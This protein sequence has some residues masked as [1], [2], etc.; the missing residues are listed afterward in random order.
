MLTGRYRPWETFGID[1]GGKAD[2]VA[3]QP[4]ERDVGAIALFGMPSDVDRGAIIAALCSEGREICEL[5]LVDT[6]L[7]LGVSTWK[8]CYRTDEEAEEAVALQP[9]LVLVEDRKTQLAGTPA[10]KLV[11]GH[12]IEQLRNMEH[13]FSDPDLNDVPKPE[14]FD[15]P[16]MEAFEKPA[17]WHEPI[18][19]ENLTAVKLIVHG[20]LLLITG[21][22]KSTQP[23]FF[24]GLFS[25]LT[26]LTC[27]LQQRP[28]DYRLLR[29]LPVFP[30]ARNRK[31]LTTSVFG[32]RT[33]RGQA[34]TF[35]KQ[36]FQVVRDSLYEAAIPEQQRR[37]D[38]H[39]AKDVEQISNVWRTNLEG[40]RMTD[41]VHTVLRRCDLR[42]LK[43]CISDSN[44]TFIVLPAL[45][46]NTSIA[47][48]SRLA[49]PGAVVDSS[50]EGLRREVEQPLCMLMDAFTE[51]IR[52]EKE[53]L[54]R[55]FELGHFGP[56]EQIKVAKNYLKRMRDDLEKA[57]VKAQGD[58]QTLLLKGLDPERL[59][60]VAIAA[61]SIEDASMPLG[62]A[63]AKAKGEA[64]AELR[65]MIRSLETGFPSAQ[66]AN[67]DATVLQATS[68][69][70]A[71]L[72]GQLRDLSKQ[73]C[74]LIAS[75]TVEVQRQAE[76]IR[77]IASPPIVEPAEGERHRQQIR[78]ASELTLQPSFEMLVYS[79]LSEQQALDLNAIDPQLR[80]M[81]PQ[82]SMRIVLCQ[83]R[84]TRLRH[85]G[86]VSEMAQDAHEDL[87][88]LSARMLASL[89]A[90]ET[91]DAPY[92]MQ[93][94]QDM[95]HAIAW[96]TGCHLK[97]A[98]DKLC[99]DMQRL[100]GSPKAE[101]ASL[102]QQLQDL[103]VPKHETLRAA[104]MLAHRVGFDLGRVHCLD[105]N[106]PAIGAE[107]GLTWPDLVDGSGKHDD[108]ETPTP[109]TT[110]SPA[111]SGRAAVTQL[112]RANERLIVLAGGGSPEEPA[113]QLSETDVQNALR[114]AE[115]RLRW[116][117]KRVELPPVSLMQPGVWSPKPPSVIEISL[118][119]D[120]CASMAKVICHKRNFVSLAASGLEWKQVEVCPKD[121]RKITHVRLAEALRATRSF[122]TA[123]WESFGV[124]DLRVDDYITVE[125]KGLA[126]LTTFYQ[127]ARLREG[128]GHGVAFDPRI[129]A[130]EFA[131]RFMLRP[132]QSTLVRE[133]EQSASHSLSRCQQMIMVTSSTVERA[134][135]AVVAPTPCLVLL[136]LCA[137]R[138]CESVSQ[139]GGKSAVV[140][141]LL[142]LLLADGKTLIVLV[143][144]DN[145]LDMS[146][147]V[148]RAAF[149]PTIPTP[150]INFA[151]E[152]SGSDDMQK[153]LRSIVRK[154]TFTRANAGVTCTTPGAVKSLFLT[155]IDRLHVEER[156]CKLLLLPKAMLLKKANLTASQ[157]DNIDRIGNVMKM[158]AGE[159]QLCRDI[160][161]ILKDGVALVDEV[162]M[163]LHP[164]RSELNFPI[165]S[166]HEL[167]LARAPEEEELLRREE[168]DARYRWMLPMHMLDAVMAALEEPVSYPDMLNKPGARET[169]GKLK[170]VVEVGVRDCHVSRTPHFTLLQKN[171]YD[172]RMRPELASWAMLFVR[173][174]IGATCVQKDRPT[175][176]DKEGGEKGFWD[177]A[178]DYMLNK[179]TALALAME[180][181]NARRDG[182]SLEQ[183]ERTFGRGGGAISAGDRLASTHARVWYA[184]QG[185]QT[186]ALLNLC[187]TYLT[188]LLPHVLSKRSRVDFGLLSDEDAKRLK[189]MEWEE[190]TARTGGSEHELTTE[191]LLVINRTSRE[192]LAVPFTGKDAPSKAAEFAIPE[193]IIGLT[194]AA[195]RIE[196]LRDRDIVR[197]LT[198]LLLDFSKDFGSPPDKR[199]ENKM[200]FA[201]QDAAAE[202]WA[203]LHGEDSEPPEALPLQMLQPSDKRHVLLL[204]TL[205]GREPQAIAYY[206]DSIVFE[207]TQ[208]DI[209]HGGGYAA[210]KLCASGMDLGSDSLFKCSVGFSGTPSDLLP[211]AMRPC[212]PTE[213]DDAK[214]INVL[215]DPD[216]MSIHYVDPPWSS[217][218]LLKLIARSRFEVLIDAGALITGKTNEQVAKFMLEQPQMSWAKA[219][220]FMD[221]QDR[222]QV[223][224]RGGGPAVPF[225]QV[226]IPPSD[227]FTFFDQCHVVG[228]DIK[229]TVNARAAVT[230]SKGMVLRDFAQACW[231]M[232]QIGVGQTIKII[233]VPEVV[234]LVDELRDRSLA[235]PSTNQEAPEHPQES[236]L[237][238]VMNWLIQASLEA[239]RLANSTL[240]TQAAQNVPRRLALEWLRDKRS[241]ASDDEA[242][243]P[244]AASAP[245]DEVPIFKSS[246]L[247]MPRTK[248]E[249]ARILDEEVP[250]VDL[251]VSTMVS[252]LSIK[253]RL[254]EE[255][256]F[257]ALSSTYGHIKSSRDAVETL[258]HNCATAQAHGVDFGRLMAAENLL[259]VVCEHTKL[260]RQSSSE[261]FDPDEGEGGGGSAKRHREKLA[262]LYAEL[263]EIDA[264]FLPMQYKVNMSA[265]F[266]GS[267]FMTT[268]SN[269]SNWA[270]EDK[271][272]ETA[273]RPEIMDLSKYPLIGEGEHMHTLAKLLTPAMH[274]RLR[275]AELASHCSPSWLAMCLRPTLLDPKAKIGVVAPNAE[276]YELFQELFRPILLEAQPLFTA[277]QCV[278]PDAPSL[279]QSL[280]IYR[281]NQSDATTASPR[282]VALRADGAYLGDWSGPTERPGLVVAKRVKGAAS[283]RLE[284]LSGA[285]QSATALER[286]EERPAQGAAPRSDV[287]WHPSSEGS[288]LA[289]LGTLDAN[290]LARLQRWLV[291]DPSAV[292]WAR[293]G[294]TR[295]LAGVPFMPAMTAAD[296][297]KVA[298]AVGTSI[299]ALVDRYSH[300]TGGTN[301]SASEGNEGQLA[302]LAFGGVYRTIEKPEE[303]EDDVFHKPSPGS[304]LH[305][306]GAATAWPRSRGVFR[307]ADP[308]RKVL[309][310]VN[311]SD[312]LKLQVTFS[313][314]NIDEQGRP[315]GFRCWASAYT[316]IAHQLRQAQGGHTF[317]RSPLFGWLSLDPKLTGS[318]FE[319]ALQLQLMYGEEDAA[320]DL[321]ETALT[322]EIALK[323][324]E[325]PG[326]RWRAASKDQAAQ[327]HHIVNAALAKELDKGK[328]EFTR[329]ELEG[330]KVQ[331]VRADSVVKAGDGGRPTYYMPAG[332]A[333]EVTAEA[334]GLVRQ[335]AYGFGSPKALCESL[336]LKLEHRPKSFV[337][338]KSKSDASNK[339]AE[340]KANAWWEL[341][342]AH[343]L[344]ATEAQL[345]TKLLECAAKLR[346]RDA[347]LA[348]LFERKA[349][350]AIERGKR[351]RDERKKE[352]AAK[353]AGGAA[354]IALTPSEKTVGSVRLFREQLQQDLLVSNR[355]ASRLAPSVSLAKSYEG[356]GALIDSFEKYISS[357]KRPTLAICLDDMREAE[358]G[359]TGGDEGTEG[360]NTEMV[361][362]QEQQQEME[363]E[364][365]VSFGPFDEKIVPVIKHWP[366]SLLGKPEDRDVLRPLCELKIRRGGQC[367]LF[368]HEQ[369][370]VR[371][372]PNWAAAD[373]H[374]PMKRR[375]RNIHLFVRVSWPQDQRAGSDMSGSQESQHCII[376]LAEAEA[377][378]RHFDGCSRRSSLK[379]PVAFPGK[380]VQIQ[381]LNGIQLVDH[382]PA[383]AK[384]RRVMTLARV[385]GSQA[386]LRDEPGGVPGYDITTDQ[387]LTLIDQ[388][389]TASTDSL[390]NF[391]FDITR[392]R[393]RFWNNEFYFVKTELLMLVTTLHALGFNQT[394]RRELFEEMLQGRRRDK[395]ATKGA[396]VDEVMLFDTA[397]ELK[398]L[399]D[400]LKQMTSRLGNTL[401]N[402]W[403]EMDMDRNGYVDKD[404]L[405]HALV[406]YA[407]I[408]PL[409]SKWIS[410]GP[411]RPKTGNEVVNSALCE[412]LA[413]GK[414]EFSPDELK[415][416]KNELRSNAFVEAR[417]GF[418]RDAAWEEVDA[419][420]R[421]FGIGDTSDQ[422]VGY[423][424]FMSRAQIWLS[425]QQDEGEDSHL[426]SIQRLER[427][428]SN[429]REEGKTM[430]TAPTST[431]AQATADKGNSQLRPESSGDRSRSTDVKTSVRMQHG[432]G[433]RSSWQP[434]SFVLA[435]EVQLVGTLSLVVGNELDMEANNLLATRSGSS[436]TI[437]P[438]GVLL[439]AGSGRWFF[440]VAI[441]RTS[442]SGSVCCGV[443]SER[444]QADR[445]ATGVGDDGNSWGVC[446]QG[447]RHGGTTRSLGGQPWKDGDVIGCL[448]DCGGRG[449]LRFSLNG[450]PIGSGAGAAAFTG[451]RGTVGVCPA[452]TIDC[453]FHGYFNLG[454][455]GFRYPPSS[456]AASVHSFIQEERATL[457][458][459]L[460]FELGTICAVANGR[461]VTSTKLEG[462]LTWHLHRPV[463]YFWAYATVALSGVLITKGKHYFEVA[464]DGGCGNIV[465]GCI[466]VLFGKRERIARFQPI[467]HEK[468]SWGMSFGTWQDRTGLVWHK[469]KRQLFGD[470]SRAKP[471]GSLTTFKNRIDGALVVGCAIDAD[472][473]TMLFVCRDA[474]T[475][476]VVSALAFE[477]MQF[478]GGLIPAVSTVHA[479]LD[480]RLGKC[481][482]LA[483]LQ[484]R[485]ELTGYLPLEHLLAQVQRE[486]AFGRGVP[487]PK[488]VASGSREP[489]WLVPSSGHDHLFF[490]DARTISCNAFLCS[491]T[492]PELPCR[493]GGLGMGFYYEVHLLT[494]GGAGTSTSFDEEAKSYDH[495]KDNDEE[496][497][498][499]A[500]G[501]LGAFGWGSR[502][503]FQGE[504]HMEKGVGHQAYSWGFAGAMLRVD[505][506]AGSNGGGA[507]G[508]AGKQQ[509][510]AMEQYASF[511]SA[512]P[513]ES[514]CEWPPLPTLASLAT[515]SGEDEDYETWVGKVASGDSTGVARPEW[516]VKMP[517]RFGTWPLWQRGG[518]VGCG[519]T[520][521]S[522]GSATIEYFYDGRRAFSQEV[523][524]PLLRGGV[525]PA[526]SLH[527]NLHV[528][529]NVGQENFVQGRD[530]RGE[531]IYKKDPPSSYFAAL[532]N[533]VDATDD[534]STLSAS[535][536]KRPPTQKDKKASANENWSEPPSVVKLI[537]EVAAEEEHARTLGKSASERGRVVAE[538]LRKLA[539]EADR[540]LRSEYE[541]KKG[542]AS[543]HSAKGLPVD[544]ESPLLRKGRRLLKLDLEPGSG[545]ASSSDDMSTPPFDEELIDAVF[546]ALER[547]P[548]GVQVQRLSCRSC[549]LKPD[550]I[551]ALAKRIEAQTA[552]RSLDVSRNALYAEGVTTLALHLRSLNDAD[553]NELDVSSNDIKDNGV[554]ALCC[555]LSA[556]SEPEKGKG[557][558]VLRLAQNSISI[559]GATSISQALTRLPLRELYLDH[560]SLGVAGA[561]VLA[562]AL[563]TGVSA[564][565]LEKLSLSDNGL[566]DEGVT[567]LAEGLS[568]NSA[569][570]HLN[571][572]GGNQLKGDGLRNLAHVLAANKRSRLC[573]LYVH[574]LGAAVDD[575]LELV[576]SM[577]LAV[578]TCESLQYERVPELYFGSLVHGERRN[579]AIQS[580]TRVALGS[581]PATDGAP[582]RLSRTHSQGSTKGENGAS[583]LPAIRHEEAVRFFRGPLTFSVQTHK[584]GTRLTELAEYLI[585][586]RLRRADASYVQPADAQAAAIEAILL[587]NA[588]DRHGMLQM[589]LGPNSRYGVH[590]FMLHEQ[591]TC[592]ALLTTPDAGVNTRKELGYTLRARCARLGELWLH[593]R[594]LK[595]RDIGQARPKAGNEVVNSA[596]SAALGQGK[597][598]FTLA[599]LEVLKLHELRADSF[600]RAG[601]YIEVGEVYFELVAPT[602]VDSA[603]ALD[604]FIPSPTD[605]VVRDVELKQD[606]WLTAHPI[607]KH[608][609]AYA[610]LLDGAKRA[611]VHARTAL[612]VAI[613]SGHQDAALLL[614]DR[615]TALRGRVLNSATRQPDDEC[616]VLLVR[617]SQS[618][619]EKLARRGA[620]LPEFN[621]G[622]RPELIVLQHPDTVDVGAAERDMRGRFVGVEA[623]RAAAVRGMAPVV[624]AL[625]DY[626]ERH[627]QMLI[628]TNQRVPCQRVAGLMGMHA[629]DA[630]N[631]FLGRTLLHDACRHLLPRGDGLEHAELLEQLVAFASQILELQDC[632]GQKEQC[633]KT[634][635]AWGRRALHYAS[636]FGHLEIIKLML[637]VIAEAD[638]QST[639]EGGKESMLDACDL[640]GW[641]PLALA[642][643]NGH[644]TACKLLVAE[645][646]DPMAPLFSPPE[647][648]P[649][650][651]ADTA[652]SAGTVRRPTDKVPCAFALSLLR[653]HFEE[654]IRP[655]VARKKASERNDDDRRKQ[656]EE[657]LATKGLQE[658]VNQFG[659]LQREVQQTR[660]G[661]S[662]WLGSCWSH[663]AA[664]IT[665]SDSAPPKM[666]IK[667]RKRPAAVR[668]AAAA[669]APSPA[670]AVRGKMA[671]TWQ[672][673]RD[674]VPAVGVLAAWESEHAP[675]SASA[676]LSD[677]LL[678]ENGALSLTTIQSMKALAEALH[679]VLL[680]APGIGDE[681]PPYY[682]R[683]YRSFFLIE[684]VLGNLFFSFLYLAL[685]TTVVLYTSGA[686]FFFGRSSAFGVSYPFVL[687]AGVGG[688]VSTEPFDHENDMIFNRVDEL[689]ALEGFLDPTDGETSPLFA[690]LLS[691][692][693]GFI[694]AQ[695]ALL[696]AVRLRLQRVAT[697]GRRCP[698][699]WLSEAQ[700]VCAVADDWF[701]AS[702]VSHDSLDTADFAGPTSGQAYNFCEDGIFC[703]V[704]N[705]TVANR[706]S[707]ADANAD[708]IGDLGSGAGPTDAFADETRGRSTSGSGTGMW[709]YWPEGRWSYGVGGHILDLPPR[710][711]PTAS[712]LV[713]NLLDDALL[714]DGV[715]RALF[716]DYT[717]YN[718]PLSFAVVVHLT[719]E[720]LSSGRMVSRTDAVALPLEWPFEGGKW[721]M[722]IAECLLVAWTL[723][724]I[725][726]E[727]KA[728]RREGLGY[729]DKWN[730]L[731]LLGLSLVLCWIVARAWWWAGLAMWSGLDPMTT[732]YVGWMQPLARLVFV[733]RA[734][735]SV[736]I[737]VSWLRVQQDLRLVPGVGPLL[738]A[739]LSTIFSAEV[740]N[741]VVVVMAFVMI[742]ALGCHVGFGADVEHFSTFD[743]AYLN[744]FAAFFGDWDKDA[745]M[746]SDTHMGDR[747]PG[748]IMWLLIAVIGLAMLS[749]V[750]IAV[751]GNVYDDLKPQMVE[752]WEE[753]VN[754]LMREDAWHTVLRS[755]ANSGPLNELLE[756]L[757]STQQ[758]TRQPFF[759]L[760]AWYLRFGLGNLLSQAWLRKYRQELA[761][762]RVDAR[763]R[764]DEEE[765]EADKRAHD[766]H[767]ECLHR[768][769]SSD[770]KTAQE[771]REHWYAQHSARK[772][773]DE[774]AD[775]ARPTEAA[776]SGSAAA[777]YGPCDSKWYEEE[778]ELR[779]RFSW[780]ALPRF[781]AATVRYELES[782]EEAVARKQQHSQDELR[783]KQAEAAS[784]Q[785]ESA[786]LLASVAAVLKVGTKKRRE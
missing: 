346:E 600:V 577:R 172:E 15:E 78:Q 617:P 312:H 478:E 547:F 683:R 410:V 64:T 219:A 551:K 317:A 4:T 12:E 430:R 249:R 197:L 694:D 353:F 611:V 303:L 734:L 57:K 229:Q 77:A 248:E 262:M 446:M 70:M 575:A 719:V 476:E 91:R 316:A 688:L 19:R 618:A 658:A 720:M 424:D 669:Q 345:V 653:L 363:E 210:E 358:S 724:K 340:L 3:Q 718:H 544:D 349:E 286:P 677:Q 716:I 764:G 39:A 492:A 559:D 436:V 599:E 625:L 479:N 782:E 714:D 650:A 63:Y 472:Q 697:H 750:F 709:G 222:K 320:D 439:G 321:S 471:F 706:A 341:S 576:F 268:A 555:N 475:D 255:Q 489:R 774:P 117:G 37:S 200:L 324:L 503:R 174:G 295:N 56:M 198:R 115:R 291:K 125:D 703:Q 515:D 107:A 294:C 632:D 522:D 26:A 284:D 331:E 29:E 207:Q 93:P 643:S 141:P 216:I 641:T 510:V 299:E 614:V 767:L 717:V 193:V 259:R 133:L 101:G 566:I 335:Y 429:L 94:S 563:K 742:F 350:K 151:F 149:G 613:H 660:R 396:P 474:L 594:T 206:L 666:F 47:I 300:E 748:A 76:E 352:E 586:D 84:C 7:S 567:A 177:E 682:A 100:Q 281:P 311:H 648:L 156:A 195:Y 55:S 265:V 673:L 498:I 699:S 548:D 582:P 2:A 428:I 496:P 42:S 437:A 152:R 204:R 135:R 92:P 279:A 179:P 671:G 315:E 633:W 691:S 494:L 417:G 509:E 385:P 252:E 148:T 173:Y 96:R 134:S 89:F 533:R 490:S 501:G 258:A 225:L 318:M 147:T 652:E 737:I 123:Q 454:K 20:K 766:R 50:L 409:G 525:V 266:F 463:P 590:R 67:S 310:W 663:P 129:I 231:R 137:L 529:V 592:L 457:Y 24:G 583:A 175:L 25:L 480:V 323:A 38:G 661:V 114:C 327:G 165:G 357:K 21:G 49:F 740:A 615:L 359:G 1:A 751:I 88:K 102:K 481:K 622:H 354:M 620:E 52:K 540:L 392:I 264:K 770:A 512:D 360:L 10:P 378:V 467:G 638:E 108:G 199:K 297:A 657:C 159:A 645:G 271:K 22:A 604:V 73:V 201:W 367:D 502:S 285:S 406:N 572:G 287:A 237:R 28:S 523:K 511:L 783:E 667:A 301:Q 365:E 380:R 662:G 325:S 500:H 31:P 142:S 381:S 506:K 155:Y 746:L 389:G 400:K 82:L 602:L 562:A 593:S 267:A 407:D 431:I 185:T 178:C 145:L 629:D 777:P 499:M 530:D 9:Q 163:V 383:E 420:A 679:K 8:G 495:N 745:M 445:Q 54:V 610:L 373:H 440:E 146:A 483:E 245:A 473:G 416:F 399:Q 778:V 434:P 243:A 131:G 212:V 182:Q 619:R 654:E 290:L 128:D 302:R 240:L 452:L 581:A 415:V 40:V 83:L 369:G 438:R 342:T 276:A 425:M 309:I 456:E 419:I 623:L 209:V 314:C 609:E 257:N 322:S 361:Q 110:G 701:H 451:V 462:E 377:L 543:S 552:L 651:S 535:G 143:V 570:T 403:D 785:A 508:A 606:L 647:C 370:S 775:K 186:L 351:L 743:L 157:L 536:R 721:L 190:T 708:A 138:S 670:S 553:L 589:M 304:E 568:R 167:Q 727:L 397:R 735:S 160:L 414:L 466:D 449:E 738:S 784:A 404:E 413:R 642:T 769:G 514:K 521:K 441:L 308:D 375:L 754:K 578:L 215:T 196:G 624:T 674:L 695:N 371:F 220:V 391:D 649:P 702:E 307:N 144:P 537:E 412:A 598:E 450:K 732:E 565:S 236:A 596:L 687:Q 756:L 765:T 274:A 405:R 366:P 675:Q 119:G 635:D 676:D 242:A 444:F 539:H 571:L 558:R 595:W 251:R 723:G 528:R 545:P 538:R 696:G 637:V 626:R 731:D 665:P 90:A 435:V 382:Q 362:E 280:A 546:D 228:M 726:I 733:Q 277:E 36:A 80:A 241:D 45:E 139:G 685:L 704:T 464:V 612:L 333:A 776:A 104:Y 447:A 534:S 507:V 95:L 34:W 693:D 239:E 35:F 183:V 753:N 630:H 398:T 372:S 524:A 283:T 205:L 455:H 556:P 758:P 640:Q 550:N 786:S 426:T 374:S 461:S 218:E 736:G 388:P 246:F 497:S 516:A 227:R 289:H 332:P 379:L 187:R 427:A 313:G 338:S 584:S 393:L 288:D 591:A 44:Q 780:C 659:D 356:F 561:Q 411:H 161:L 166:K 124:S 526:I 293:F 269:Q 728:W 681:E 217:N 384:L 678:G 491:L 773:E 233:A 305:A 634:A 554:A 569:L 741:F 646:A 752:V 532:R 459:K 486:A 105:A 136:T 62:D 585:R 181:G 607:L 744:V 493:S 655:A 628:D 6:Q 730:L 296:L 118:F 644:L 189:L 608:P 394:V 214:T 672:N 326:L 244:A 387:L 698:T 330:L 120:K 176:L 17:R 485:G 250:L 127:P 85:L 339:D 684:R 531:L 87:L 66:I 53:P 715:T 763:A 75:E 69:V 234:K 423:D 16:L 79:Q 292:G 442:A 664:R 542:V 386:A 282:K 601:A 689:E 603:T 18:P 86:M 520:V 560:N 355:T 470:R 487:N 518:V 68:A 224:F 443:V 72:H 263:Q 208:R 61:H 453:G 621:L 60:T 184:L 99:A 33:D 260:L 253:S 23:P 112:K 422:G 401:D 711:L 527:S 171:F 116:R 261:L 81:R 465:I 580:S 11:L 306:A 32:L 140:A 191:E 710:D 725:G 226:N 668:Q 639:I 30:T 418:Y 59:L 573:Q 256:M 722:V 759:D 616:P 519:V 747:S 549:T 344:G 153:Q 103:G 109:R 376:T 230:I 574:E 364:E 164:L 97:N 482:L 692:D 755:L 557:I 180:V 188:A 757:P 221:A 194:V 111:G 421:G 150:V 484:G 513:R 477:G 235:P 749:N 254:E 597:L 98:L 192:L 270:A 587:R 605:Y 278:H 772:D 402:L 579:D 336:G 41:T 686:G 27:A 298:A 71:N 656:F 13:N 126:Q 729:L 631:D 273:H 343:C 43:P 627:G 588:A 158:R 432:G 408:Q 768:P 636:A 46:A 211:P 368:A 232:R 272:E 469:N 122:T 247:P 328:L 213:G 202:Y 739:F 761:L 760:E 168:D 488:G 5:T 781:D 433:G 223:V 347:L 51:T 448:I 707:A 504:Y 48:A 275:A 238:N 713:R 458:R 348:A 541:W 329:V 337:H 65:Q 74:A 690:I 390:K 468:H 121:G 154:L 705:A 170:R 395:A 712:A 334:E 106:E 517:E 113:E 14:W 58:T 700:S 779:F 130:F 680:E 564:N 771:M 505:R 319:A 162:D 169:V 132:A 460:A 203:K 762:I